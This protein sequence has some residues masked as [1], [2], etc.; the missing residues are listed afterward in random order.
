MP[1]RCL[2]CGAILQDSEELHYHRGD[3]T[4]YVG[5]VWG[6]LRQLEGRPTP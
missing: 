3:C 2:Q 4:P 5:A 6:T 1:V